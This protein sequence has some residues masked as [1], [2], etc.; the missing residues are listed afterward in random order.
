MSRKRVLIKLSGE[1]LANDAKG[2]SIDYSVVKE[3]ASEIKEL[4]ESGIEVGIV[5]G[6]GNFWRGA[7]ATKNGIDRNKADYIGML[8]TTMNALALEG[9]FEDYGVETRVQSSLQM[10]QKVTENYV[11]EIAKKYLSQGRVVIFSGGTGRPYFTTDSAAALVAAEINADTILMGKNGVDGVYDKDP[12]THS[13]AKRY[14]KI[15]YDEMLQM[16][17]KIM[18]STAAALARDNNIETM[19][20]NIKEKNAISKAAKRAPGFKFST[21]KH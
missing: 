3:I 18:D 5:V 1:G 15:T 11:N 13:D 12:K 7:S 19:V 8:A 2:L 10:D 6:G 9:A 14:D 16:N 4:V 20:F 21:I 17:L